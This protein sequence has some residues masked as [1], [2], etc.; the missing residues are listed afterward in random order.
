[1]RRRAHR[2]RHG[3][4]LHSGRRIPPD[5]RRTGES[6]ASISHS[7]LDVQRSELA[8]QHGHWRTRPEFYHLDRMRFFNPCP[9]RGMAAVAV[10]GG[11]DD[12]RRRQRRSVDVRR[13]QS[14]GSHAGAGTGQW[15]PRA[16]LPPLQ[17]GSFGLC[18][19]DG[20][21]GGAPRRSCAGRAG[22]IRATADAGHITQPSV[23]GAANAM[24]GALES[25]AMEPREIDYVNAH[26]TGTKLNDSTEIAAIKQ[27][28]G[29]DAAKISISSTKSMH[30]HAM[31]ASGAIE[32]AATLLSLKHQI[33]PPTASYSFADPEC[34]LDV[35]P[36][37][38]RPRVLRCAIS[39]SFAF[40]GLNAVLAIRRM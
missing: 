7:A 4:H 37:H 11:R 18:A 35:T 17:P 10:W 8:D 3:G 1:A 25:A 40:G 33:V 34:D 14:L 2:H 22:R 12:A 30:G 20:G 31:G 23:D 19:G 28:F 36:I 21:I 27:V 15:R 26:G 6:R 39:N 29:A 24:R 38:A 9:G 16:R 13:N 5:L 32:L